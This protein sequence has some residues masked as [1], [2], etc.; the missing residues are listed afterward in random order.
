MARPRI[1]YYD[2]IIQQAAAFSPETIHSWTGNK[3]TAIAVTGA[4]L[5]VNGYRLEF[6]D[7][8][9]YQFLVQLYQTNNF[10][11]EPLERWLREHAKPAIESE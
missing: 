6:D 1:G 11:L 10:R 9:A 2:D 4:F 8:E 5:R 3:R 7:L